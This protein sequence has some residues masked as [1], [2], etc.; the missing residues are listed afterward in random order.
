MWEAVQHFCHAL[1]SLSS[2]FKGENHVKTLY[3]AR[4]E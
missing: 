1:L 4:H 3:C 2:Y